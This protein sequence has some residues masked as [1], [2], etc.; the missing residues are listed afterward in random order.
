MSINGSEL[1]QVVHTLLYTPDRIVLDLCDRIGHRLQALCLYNCKSWLYGYCCCEGGAIIQKLNETYLSRC[2]IG[3]LPRHQSGT[4]ELHAQ[5][6]R[7]RSLP[8]VILR[9]FFLLETLA[10]K[11]DLISMRMLLMLEFYLDIS[12]SHYR[13]T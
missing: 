11:A 7:M 9:F 12:P 4:K 10:L 1:E 3:I 2:L 6:L 5:P 13:V 8:P